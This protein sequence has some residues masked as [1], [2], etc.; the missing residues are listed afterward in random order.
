MRGY[1]HMRKQTEFR[2]Y[3]PLSSS[4]G[5]G[6]GNNDNQ[7]GNEQSGQK[8]AV[9]AFASIAVLAA[10]LMLLAA[11]AASA[12]GREDRHKASP[13]LQELLATG[14]PSTVVDVIVQYRVTPQQK[15][16]DRVTSRG[17]RSKRHLG[18]IKAEAY[19]LPLS[20]VQD[21]LDDADVAH[22]SLDHKVKMTGSP[23]ADTVVINADV[24]RGYGYD[25]S[26]VGIAI[27]DAGVYAHPDLNIF[28]A[29]NSRVVYSES[30]VAGDASTNDAY[31]HGTHVAGLAAGNGR[32][33]ATGYKYQYSGVATGANIINLRVLDANGGGNDSGVIAAISRAI[34]LQSQYN[35]RVLNLSLGRGIYES[36]T[37]DPLCQAVEQAWNAGIVVVVA[38]GNAG[39]DTTLNTNG[40]A[41]ITVPGNDP[42]VITVGAMNANDNNRSNDVIASYSSR[43]PSLID[44]I[45]KPD[46][47]AP[48]NQVVSLLATNATLVN[49]NPNLDVFPCNNSGTSCGSQ[50]G[51]P[52]YF[53]LSG[54]SMATPLVSGAAAM[55]IQKDPTLTPDMVK[56]RLMKSAYKGFRA[57]STA[58]DSRG[59]TYNNQGDLFTYGAG[60]LDVAAALNNADTGVGYALSPTAVFNASNNT[61]TLIATTP[62]GSSVTWGTSILWGSSVLWGD[63]V[64]WGSNVFVNATSVLWGDSILWG[65]SVVWGDSTTTGFSVL[66]GTSVLWGD[67]AM[68]ALSE[69]DP[70]DCQVDPVTGAVTCDQ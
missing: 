46:L 66:W 47:V 53:T 5:W 21:L 33:S 8:P 22:V 26:G 49:G 30:F 62:N 55:M 14:N 70:G 51:S 3:P 54:T 1:T 52:Q 29:S 38:A 41:T 67:S 34:Q 25:G 58:F 13:P 10:C 6:A 45:V 35:I 15:H 64:V 4:A 28:G 11:P 32:T 17:G 9:R 59:H 24:A 20:A 19:T 23:S 57:Y 44:H 12:K 56:A 63:S 60:Y 42:Y 2:T 18:V 61:V 36:Y 40:Y 48:G 68:Q 37:L 50:Y 43:G 39:R 31:G 27:V 69:D 16:R 7:K 65:S